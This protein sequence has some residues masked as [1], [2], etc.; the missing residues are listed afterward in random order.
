MEIF[1]ETYYGNGDFDFVQDQHTKDFL[2]SA[3]K[4]ITLCELWNWMRTF[5]PLPN[6]GFILTKTPELDR[7]KLHMWKDT[8]NSFHSG[9]SYALIMRDMQFIAK[10]GYLHFRLNTSY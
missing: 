5:E 7:L 10:H 4:A 8:I 1:D 9:S 3:H 2:K 6:M